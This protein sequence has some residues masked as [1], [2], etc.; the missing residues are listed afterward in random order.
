MQHA[1]WPIDGIS[2]HIARKI[3]SL[4]RFLQLLQGGSHSSCLKNEIIPLIQKERALS[5]VPEMKKRDGCDLQ[6]A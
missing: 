6:K 1:F 2:F 4:L 3:C 5:V